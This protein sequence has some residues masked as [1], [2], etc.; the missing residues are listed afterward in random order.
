MP[1]QPKV[2]GC[3]RC[4][5]TREV[6]WYEEIDFKKIGYFICQECKRYEKRLITIKE[7]IALI[8]VNLPNK[9]VMRSIN[10]MKKELRLLMGEPQ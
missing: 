4:T 5:K 10:K 1:K 9:T 3:K 2:W 6:K 7:Q 8:E